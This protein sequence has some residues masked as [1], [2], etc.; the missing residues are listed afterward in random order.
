MG[1]YNLG[2]APQLFGARRKGGR[3]HAGIDLGT[4]GRKG[5]PVGCPLSGFRVASVSRRGGY[6]N[7]V[8]LVSEDGKYMMRFAHLAN[9]LPTHLKKGQKVEYGDYLGDVGGTGGNY[10]IHLH[11]EL[12]VKKGDKY[13]PVNPLRNPYC[14]FTKKI[15][16]ESTVA[17]YESRAAVRSG[18][19]ERRGAR[20]NR[21]I[22]TF[23][24][25]VPKPQ[26][27][28]PSVPP[29]VGKRKHEEQP[30]PQA[31]ILT[32]GAPVSQQTE[33]NQN[34]YFSLN[35]SFGQP[36]LWQ[37]VMPKMFGGWSKE[38]LKRAE[39]ERK[40]DEEVIKGYTRRELLQRGLSNQDIGALHAYV[41]A[42]AQAGETLAN[43]S[44]RVNL[45]EV[46]DN[47]QTIAA[48][49]KIFGER[50]MS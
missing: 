14:C 3:R 35:R 49:K 27:V 25:P 11:F 44:V 24:E 8:D 37:R 15:F 50:N 48:A 21:T 26:K 34:G 41:V 16:E 2:W 42:K 13:V 31:P 30:K 45:K 17:A 28:T 23:T 10:A 1:V 39:Q 47:Q 9:P 18:R 40:L 36:T 29:I 5:V 46:F 38:E 6:G 32:R 33:G 19:V 22:A 20:P 12:R 4:A 7:T 43:N